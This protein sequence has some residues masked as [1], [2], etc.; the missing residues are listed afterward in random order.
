MHTVLIHL[1]FVYTSC[2][3]CVK[4]LRSANQ[5]LHI[6]ILLTRSVCLLFLGPSELY[7]EH[8]FNELNCRSIGWDAVCYRHE[9]VADVHSLLHRSLAVVF[10]VKH[11]RNALEDE[12]DTW[13]QRDRHM[14]TQWTDNTWSWSCAL[15][16][17]KFTGGWNGVTSQWGR[18]LPPAGSK[19][20]IVITGIKKAH[21]YIVVCVPHI[22]NKDKI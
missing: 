1:A 8:F 14:Y 9:T 15:L 17:H 7:N 19:C 6:N 18:Y 3:V 21:E 16:I 4:L 13:W 2:C 20:E 11:F 12:Q 10:W 5:S 22:T